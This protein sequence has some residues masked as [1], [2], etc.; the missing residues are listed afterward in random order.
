MSIVEFLRAVAKELAMPLPVYFYASAVAGALLAFNQGFARRAAIKWSALISPI[1]QPI[2]EFVRKESFVDIAGLFPPLLGGFVVLA[3]SYLVSL[4]GFAIAAALFIE[5]RGS[6][7]DRFAEF[8]GGGYREVDRRFHELSE[9]AQR[10]ELEARNTHQAYRIICNF[11]RDMTAPL[12]ISEFKDDLAILMDSAVS[13]VFGSQSCLR[14][15]LYLHVPNELDGGTL[16]LAAGHYPTRQGIPS[17]LNREW[18]LS[19]SIAGKCFSTGANIIYPND[20]GSKQLYSRGKAK[21]GSSY[22]K[23]FVCIRIVN[24]QHVWGVLS[25]DSPTTTFPELTEGQ[26]LFLRNLA[27]YVGEILDYSNGCAQWKPVNLS[28]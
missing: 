9:K 7:F 23:S 21:K 27:L 19:G 16:V 24:K 4:A 22:T 18:P 3:A 2:I 13:L 25:V 15:A 12:S 20:K 5:S 14:I 11:L 6:W 10:L 26:I 17:H 8:M 1:S 28:N